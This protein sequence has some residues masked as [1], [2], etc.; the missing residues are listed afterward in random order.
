MLSKMTNRDEMI[1]FA[2]KGDKNASAFLRCWVDFCHL[3]DDIH[4][5]DKPV[6]TPQIVALMVNLILNI[7]GN[8]FYQAHRQRFES[9]IEQSASAW[10]SSND[11]KNDPDQRRVFAAD[12]LKGYYHEVIF[13]AARL[14]GGW[15]HEL[16]TAQKYREYDFE[17][18]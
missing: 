14:V 3:I 4:D 12:V 16:E 5:K 7:G 9:L 18:K 10:L 1:E 13:H 8:P 2:A 6:E 15:Q 17:K 11:W